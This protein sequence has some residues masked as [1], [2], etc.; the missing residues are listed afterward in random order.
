MATDNDTNPLLSRNDR[1]DFTNIRPAHALPAIRQLIQE[2]EDELEKIKGLTEPRTFSNTMLAL[3]DLGVT[4]DTAVGIVGHIENVA[5]TAEWREAYNE[6]VPIVTQFKSKIL[7]DEK[8]WT[9][10]K[11]YSDTSDAQ[12]LIGPRKRYLKKTL[13]SFRRN[14]ADL[15][16]DKKSELSL[17]MTEL[18]QVTNTF[19]QRTLDATAQ[20]EFYTEDLNQLKGLPESALM[21][22]RSSAASKGKEGWRY[23]LQAPSYIAILT[24]LDDQKRRE[25]FYK[26]YNTRCTAGPLENVSLIHTIL[27]LRSKKSEILGFSNFADLV[28]EDRMAGSGTKAKEFVDDL[29]ERV[30]PFFQ[31]EQEELTDFVRSTFGE[32]VLPLK[33]WD[34]AYYA[35]KMRVALYDFDEELLRPYFP[36]PSVMKGLFGVVEKIFGISIE[37]RVDLPVWDSSVTTYSA[38]DTSNRALIGHFYAD[39]SPRENKRSGAW[40]DTFNAGITSG[41][42]PLPHIGLIAGNFTPASDGKDPLLSHD[43]VN[44]LFHEFG[45]LLHLLCSKAELRGQTM[46]GVAWD[47]IELPS[48]IMENW[49]WE[50]SA[51]DMF[52]RH[53]ETGERIPDELFQKMVRAKNFRSASALMRQVG[54][55][56]MDLAIHTEYNRERDGEILSYA[57]TIMQA[58][59]SLQLPEY[60]SLLTTFTHLFSGSVAYACGY[61]SYQWAEVLDAD[62]FSRFKTEGIL[63]DTVG[64]EFREVILSKGDTE[65]P[66]DLFRH[67]MGRDPRVEPLLERSGLK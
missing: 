6:I 12:N 9:A 60:F 19:A 41:R 32:G 65:P 20:F 29:R 21:M 7:F 36:L 66:Q 16:A 61:Y 40:M 53:F 3:D 38:Y 39:F 49:C 2:A 51:L 56:T 31:K 18:S 5:S 22:G 67:F 52:A 13:D 57:R 58:H 43:E 44:T 47:F 46:N 30:R 37:K 15:P 42:D 25:E 10:L 45:H 35:E 55:S 33:P 50:R 8:L 11:E 34:L 27:Q 64:K 1:I 26:A 48:Q 62:A 17:L 63:N 4:L 14:G 59:S 24:Y 54:L 23:T 28:L